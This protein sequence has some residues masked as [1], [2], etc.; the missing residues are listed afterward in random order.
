MVWGEATVFFPTNVLYFLQ[1]VKSKRVKEK[2][3]NV[4]TS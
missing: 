4:F 1:H 3:N 2:L